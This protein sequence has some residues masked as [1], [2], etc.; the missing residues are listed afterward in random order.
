M[1]CQCVKPFWN[2]MKLVPTQ[3][4]K[5]DPNG[6]LYLPIT[7]TMAPYCWYQ[8][9]SLAL[10]VVLLTSASDIWEVGR[11][12]QILYYVANFLSQLKYIEI[13]ALEQKLERSEKWF[14][15]GVLKVVVKVMIY[16]RKIGR[17][18]LLSTHSVVILSI[19]LNYHFFLDSEVFFTIFVGLPVYLFLA[20]LDRLHQDFHWQITDDKKSNWG[21]FF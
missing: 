15:I 16:I 17:A 10:I 5:R 21:F 7:F 2:T 4:F 18:I 8:Y 19:Q 14:F 1:K 11:A 13:G 12:R 9:K 3:Y 20:K 6:Y